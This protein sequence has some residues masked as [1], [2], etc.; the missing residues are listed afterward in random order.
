M[1]R[2]GLTPVL[3]SHFELVSRAFTVAG[4]AE[5]IKMN[6]PP[7]LPLLSVWEEF[8]DHDVSETWCCLVRDDKEIYGYL[9][10][11]DPIWD[12]LQ[13]YQG[14]AA[15]D[16]VIPISPGMIVAAS[17]PLLE[18]IPLFGSSLFFFVLTRNDLTHVV[19]Y[20][21]LDKL[22]LKL[23]LF[24]L[25]MELESQI[26]EAIL[27]SGSE[28]D[29]IPTYISKQRLA[30]AEELCRIKYKEV[31]SRRLLLCTTFVDKKEILYKSPKFNEMLP[32][33]SKRL[34][35]RFFARVENVRNQ[36]AHGDSIVSVLKTP[37]E[38]N[39][40]ISDLRMTIEVVAGTIEEIRT[41]Q[42][43][44]TVGQG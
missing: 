34:S 2:E 4:V 19:T 1:T 42:T 9:S 5:P 36:I 11:E 37:A 39:C 32:F 31:T 28:I 6:V 7:E 15:V 43:T 30:R 40:F 21:D 13:E 10:F 35:D 25:F 17:L 14:R 44:L 23:S 41:R 27:S 3:H 29:R 33:R 18:L 22:P 16:E 24:S 38:L 12:N 26:V 20:Y 8:M